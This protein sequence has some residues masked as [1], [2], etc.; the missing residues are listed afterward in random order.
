MNRRSL[1]KHGEEKAIEFLKEKGYEI[2][3]T[4]YLKRSGEI[5]I[6][7]FDPKYREYVFVEVKTRQSTRFG[8]PEEAVNKNKINKIEK[9]AESW[10]MEK[11]KV[12]VEWRVDIIS[13]ELTDKKLQIRHIQNIS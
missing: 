13:I 7:A 10:L 8:Y 6:I 3:E 1:G 2:I 4:N 11:E 12:D 9:T 5:D